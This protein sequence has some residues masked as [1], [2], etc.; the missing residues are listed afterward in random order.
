ML[1]SKV[2]CDSCTDAKWLHKSRASLVWCQSF[3]GFTA[4]TN[5]A[6]AFSES[7]L[8]GTHFVSGTCNHDN[9]T[10]QCCLNNSRNGLDP[11]GI[12]RQETSVPQQMYPHT[13]AHEQM[14][15]KWLTSSGLDM[16]TSVTAMSAST[17]LLTLCFNASLGK[18]TPC[19]SA[20][21][22]ASMQ[23][24][25]SSLGAG[26]Q[27]AGPCNHSH[28]HIKLSHMILMKLLTVPQEAD[29]SHVQA[30]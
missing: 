11:A 15:L 23:M 30:L 9:V 3:S 18:G 27:F 25:L 21:C 5:L 20:C 12:S 24:D 10:S 19:S 2:T 22:A 28:M 29:N 1:S 17:A 26:F 8:H 7:A 13:S 14:T 4:V 6:L 16:P